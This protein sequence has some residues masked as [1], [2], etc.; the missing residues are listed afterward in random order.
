M[1]ADPRN[2]I[3][4]PA[5]RDNSAGAL[6]DAA[7]IAEVLNNV[8]VERRHTALDGHWTAESELAFVQ[9]LGPRSELFVAEA[10]GRIVGFQ[11]VEPF[12][13]Y[14]STMDHV[15]IMGTY[16]H[17]EYRGQ[18]IGKRLAR[19]SL[20]FCR[21]QGFEKIVIYVLVHN[22]TAR[23]YY[24]SLGF[25]ERGVLRWQTKIDGVYHDEVFMELHLDDGRLA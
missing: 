12:A 17:G 13:A 9:S 25:E 19:A 1:G 2:L 3:L 21:A 16:V 6:A 5:R 20:D 8:I 24:G 10:G 14:T 11:V 4:R 18:G 7:G 22:E 23:A 15:A